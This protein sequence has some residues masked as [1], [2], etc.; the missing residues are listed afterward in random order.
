M[1]GGPPIGLRLSGG[2]AAG[3]GEGFLLLPENGQ[4]TS[5]QV[6]WDLSSLPHGAIGVMS[7]GEA[8]TTLAGGPEEFKEQW[9]L[10]GPAGVYRASNGLPF[11]PS[12]AD[13]PGYSWQ[14][15]ASVATS[16]C[17]DAAR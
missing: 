15:K 8:D 16:S 12:G 11:T 17:V 1:G 9:F 10:V 7:V 14:R 4:S 5:T 6:H 2:G 3:E 13:V